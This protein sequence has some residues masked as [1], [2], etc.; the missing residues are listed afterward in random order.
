M[1]LCH[2]VVFFVLIGQ[3]MVFM[4][5]KEKL[6]FSQLPSIHRLQHRAYRLSLG[7]IYAI[8]GVEATFYSFYV[9]S[10]RCPKRKRSPAWGQ[11]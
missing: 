3:G 6:Y 10:S 8:L 9:L 2:I 1:E 11:T 4:G 5:I 7:R